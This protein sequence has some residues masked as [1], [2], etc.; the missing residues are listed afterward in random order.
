MDDQEMRAIAFLAMRVRKATHGAGPWDEPG[1]MTN[2]RKVQQ[3][4]LAHTIE[5]V[6]RHAADPKVKSPGVIASSFKPAKLPE[7]QPRGSFPPKRSE[8]CSEHV[9]ELP[10][11]FC[12]I[13]AVGEVRAWHDLEVDPE[14]LPAA[15]PSA[16]AAAIRDQIR[17]AKA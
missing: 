8:E 1:V 16:A 2:L 10:P 4:G 11:P 14:P 12:K 9:G 3:Q 17:K 13:H 5:N 6:I 15:D 7:P